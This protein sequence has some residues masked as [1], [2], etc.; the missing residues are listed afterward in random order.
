[1]VILQGFKKLNI[2][3]NISRSSVSRNNYNNDKKESKKK[4]VNAAAI[5][6]SAIGIAAGVAGVYALAKK[7]NPS[8]GIKNINYSE[9]DVLMIG[10]GSVLGG[11]AGGLIADDDKKNVK[12]KLREASQQFFGNMCCPIGLLALGN[13]VLDKTNFRLP[14]INS[15]SKPAMAVNGVLKVLPKVAVTLGALFGGMEIGNGIMNKVNN[16]IFKEEVKHDIEAEDYLVHADDLCL[17]ANMLLKD[18]AAISSV[19]SKV[20]P[21]TFIVAGSK[22]GMQKA[23]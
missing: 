19:T 16:K 22:T 20:L 4:K 1:M 15:A 5:T 14:K 8:L 13:K 2:L 9:G 7:G 23:D 11:L 6:G 21:A 18:S 17:A 12:P 3:N 10:A